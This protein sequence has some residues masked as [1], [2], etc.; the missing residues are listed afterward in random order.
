MDK[1]T[2]D[3]ANS[4]YIAWSLITPT[5]KRT[6]KQEI[7]A[8]S[9]S[10]NDLIQETYLVIAANIANYDPEKSQF[11]A[12][13]AKFITGLT[14]EINNPG[15]SAY[16]YSRMGCR[17]MSMDALNNTNDATQNSLS[18]EETLMDPNAT[19]EVIYDQKQKNR[20]DK[21]FQQVIKETNKNQENKFPEKDMFINITFLHKFLGGIENMPDYMKDN[22]EASL[23]L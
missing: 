17:I 7:H 13:I 15:I 6:Y 4:T 5:L 10:V 12:Y 11:K 16:Q 18:F 21:L 9:E 8:D 19:I 20:S 22:I 2:G 3:Y 14:R 1:R 23:G